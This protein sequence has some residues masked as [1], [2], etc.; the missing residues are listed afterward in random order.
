MKEKLLNL[1][2]AINN[3]FGKVP[4]VA[5]NGMLMLWNPD[6]TNVSDE[7]QDALTDMDWQCSH[8]D[9]D[10][11]FDARLTFSPKP[12]ADSVAERAL[13]NLSN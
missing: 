12:T 8:R 5:C 10:R 4:S 1:I 7:I 3:Q 2:N 6:T 13:A 9:G 11:Q